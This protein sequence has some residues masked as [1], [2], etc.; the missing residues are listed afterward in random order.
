MRYTDRSV[1]RVGLLM[2]PL[3]A[4]LVSA[5][6]GSSRAPAETTPKP[7]SGTV[8]ASEMNRTAPNQDVEKYLAGR[9]SGV[10]VT[11]SNGGLIIRIRGQSSISGNNSPL[12]VI[13]GMAVEPGPGGALVG[14]NPFD[15]DT[16]KVLKDAT[17]LTMYGSRGANGVIVIKTK[18]R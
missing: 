16:I 2:A 18:K 10:V 8:T 12:Y 3:A 6:C 15:I 1:R 9:V 5:G 11:Q 14:L 7:S 17:D 13:D 4:L